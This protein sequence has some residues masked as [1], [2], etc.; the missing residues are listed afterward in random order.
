MKSFV[1]LSRVGRLVGKALFFF[2]LGIFVTEALLDI[3]PTRIMVAGSQFSISFYVYI[4][5]FDLL[6]FFWAGM[7][8][9]GIGAAL[10]AFSKY[11]YVPVVLIL[12][13]I[14]FYY[15]I[16]QSSSLMH[17]Y[18]ITYACHDAYSSRG[19]FSGFVCPLSSM[20]K[21][22]PTI[23]LQGSVLAPI[24]LVVSLVSYA[25][26]RSYAGV[27]LALTE[28][29]M[30]GSGIVCMYEL[31]IFEYQRL[32]FTQRVT[33]YQKLVYLGNMTNQELLTICLTILL[34]S[35]CARIF[36][37]YRGRGKTTIVAPLFQEARARGSK[38]MNGSRS[39]GHFSSL[40]HSLGTFLL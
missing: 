3:N 7:V 36:L 5:L 33:D 12:F 27:K 30:L 40:F 37:A 17:Y 23:P 4:T 25:V 29:T 19:Y 38:R 6:R 16:I 34:I 32:W 22:H 2:F 20:I 10:F 39:S 13:A 18:E 11:R 24:A 14:A 21:G 9:L 28:M 1:S 8:I 26:S 35:V 15:E 31:A